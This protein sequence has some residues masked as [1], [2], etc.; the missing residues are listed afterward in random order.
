MTN[1]EL[2][3]AFPT[4]DES[5]FEETGILQQVA[6]IRAGTDGYWSVIPTDPEYPE[7]GPIVHGPWA[8][9]EEAEEFNDAEVGCPEVR[10]VEVRSGQPVSNPFALAR[11]MKV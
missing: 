9:Y 10:I 4:S 3:A 5:K 11:I 1:D 7:D 6:G 8:T 2:R